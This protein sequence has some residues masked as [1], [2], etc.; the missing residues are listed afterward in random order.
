MPSVY[1]VTIEPVSRT[2]YYRHMAKRD[3]AVWE[4]WLEKYGAGFDGVAYD[5][6]LGGELPPEG[7]MPEA[8]RLAWQY[9]TALKI[10]AVLFAPEA[11]VIVEV[12]PWA[13]VSAVGACLCYTLVA[14]REQ[15]TLL[16]L[17]PAIVCEGIQ[18]D[19]RWCCQRT[20]IT[21]WTV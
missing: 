14:E 3:A 21:V 16:P 6:A 17:Q 4:R 18:T 2:G 10:D 12:R 1:P 20:N 13:T 11:V 8:E 15:L 19:V 7:S 5:V 9:S